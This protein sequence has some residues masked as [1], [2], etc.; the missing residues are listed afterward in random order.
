MIGPKVTRRHLLA[1]TAVG[2]ATL[3]SGSL[4]RERSTE[5]IAHRGFADER[6][7]NTVAAVRYAAP[8]ADAIEVD[9]R[10]CGSGELV[11]LHDE[12]LERTTD[13]NGRV[14]ATDWERL[15]TLRVESS[16]ARVP[17]L[18]AVFEAVPADVR[19]NVELKERG[20]APDLLELLE[21]HEV[22]VRVSSFDATALAQV[23]SLDSTV[24]LAYVVG[25]GAAPADVLETAA[26]LDCVAVHPSTAL[27]F[28]TDIIDRAHDR[29][30]DVNA[31]T[32][33]SGFETAMLSLEGVDGVFAD[34]PIPWL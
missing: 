1:G 6:P 31:W 18:E 5:V 23:E 16:D 8:R 17:R 14:G 27:C 7:E 22:T 11:C 26:E 24:P 19:L 12:R 9:V 15:K 28:E 32:V 33:D 25:D 29:G 2:G 3:L 30:F 10:H 34:T 21:R 4:A 13:G 20:L